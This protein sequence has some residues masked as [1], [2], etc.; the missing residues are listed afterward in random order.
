RLARPVDSQEQDDRGLVL[1]VERRRGRGQG[2]EQEAAEQRA[3]LARAGHRP[4]HDFLTRAVDEVGG[5]R[6]AQVRRDQ[7][8]FELFEQRVVDGPVRVENGA[9]TAGEVLLRPPEPVAE[10]PT[11]S[12]EKLHWLSEGRTIRVMTEPL[13]PSRGTGRPLSSRLTPPA[14]PIVRTKGPFEIHSRISLAGIVSSLVRRP[15]VRT[16]IHVVSVVRAIKRYGNPSPRAPT[17]EG[18]AVEAD[19]VEAGAAEV[20]A[21]EAGA[22]EVGA[23]AVTGAAAGGATMVLAAGDVLGVAT[24]LGEAVTVGA[25]CGL[26]AAFGLGATGAA[27]VAGAGGA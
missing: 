25:A 3:K 5:E 2:I 10:T 6:R 21:A 17:V 23:E 11:Q 16:R 24:T 7:D 8:L 14:L 22:V 12:R 4:E 9:E 27:F 26:G 19:A 1:E 13:A 15:S 20:S 18:G